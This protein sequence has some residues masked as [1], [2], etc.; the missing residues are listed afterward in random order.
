M[1][2]KS[3]FMSNTNRSLWMVDNDLL[4]YFCSI[5]TVNLINDQQIK[6]LPAACKFRMEF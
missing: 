4:K 5:D 2:N 6:H 1:S 3:T